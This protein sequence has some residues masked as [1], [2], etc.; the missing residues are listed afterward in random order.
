MSM[1]RAVELPKAGWLRNRTFDLALICGVTSL[2]L[3]A[4]SLIAIAPAWP[5]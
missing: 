2:A 4:A 3:V 5:D 1:V